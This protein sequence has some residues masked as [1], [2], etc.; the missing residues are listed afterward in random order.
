MSFAV[1]IFR[2]GN[3]VSEV[4][5]NWLIDKRNEVYCWWPPAHMKNITSLI[6]NRVK[7]NESTWSLLNVTVKKFCSKYL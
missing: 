6:A 4:P 7:P 3:D 5:D 1:V 2:D